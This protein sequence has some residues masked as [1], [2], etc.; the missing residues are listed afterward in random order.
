[1]QK[2]VTITFTVEELKDIIHECIRGSSDFFTNKQEDD[3]V[4]NQREAAIFLGVSEP[5][6]L[7]YK[8]EGLIPFEQLPGS[9]KIRFYKSELK[10]VVSNNRHLLQPARK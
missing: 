4:M 2:N 10:K 7:R 5:T 6:I 3:D 8:K 1:M 9:K